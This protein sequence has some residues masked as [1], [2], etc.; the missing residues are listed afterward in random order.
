MPDGDRDNAATSHGGSDEG[1]HKTGIVW[2]YRLESRQTFYGDFDTRH[3]AI[4]HAAIIGR[5]AGEDVEVRWHESMWEE[6]DEP[7]VCGYCGYETHYVPLVR[8]YFVADC[9]GS[10]FCTEQCR[11]RYTHERKE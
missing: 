11:A 5:L 10:P 1:E 6:R 2:S 7:V 8:W 4:G 3:Q 9:D